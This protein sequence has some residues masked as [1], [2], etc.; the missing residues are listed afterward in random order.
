MCVEM[1][2]AEPIL[3]QDCKDTDKQLAPQGYAAWSWRTD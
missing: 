1:N 2:L 3:N